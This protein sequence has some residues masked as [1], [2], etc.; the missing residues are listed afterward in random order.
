[1]ANIFASG[2]VVN[3]NHSDGIICHDDL[4]EIIKFADYAVCNFEAPVKGFGDPR[5][6]AGPHHNQCPRTIEGLKKQGFDLLLLA[7][8]HIMDYGPDALEATLNIARE[9]G[10]DTIG[11]GLNFTDAYKPL[12]KEFDDVKIGMINACEAQFG[13]MDH[14]NRP[15]K[16]GYAWINHSLI[17]KNILKL[18]K[19]CDFIIVFSHA[20]LE[21]YYI[22]QKEWRDRYRHFCDL[23]ADVV[24]GSHPH[25]PQGYEIYFNS[26]I[27]YSLG[28]F[29]FDSPKYK[30]KEDRSFSIMLHLEKGRMPTFEPIFHYKNN[31]RVGIA[32]L[33]KR[34]NLDNLCNMLIDEVEYE[35]A[36]DR[37]SIEAYESI[38]LP[39]LIFS[40]MPIPYNGNFKSTL[41]HLCS[42]LLGRARRTDKTLLQLHLLRNE[43]YY[44]AAKHALEVKAREKYEL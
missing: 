21:H 37:M 31:G 5:P 25:V 13:V 28:N 15:T 6:K 20:G 40:I 1:L 16:A 18:K 33:D 22:P 39:K 36:H 32:S 4:T 26:L 29:Y 24:V 42:L 7:N 44:Y 14:F 30:D 2:D 38:I 12:V 27:F 43:A 9:N 17:D 23:G 34:V 11:A 10:F 35:K 41:R 8:N 19:R 3:Y